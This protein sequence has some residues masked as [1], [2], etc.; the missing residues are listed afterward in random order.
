MRK[1]VIYDYSSVAKELLLRLGSEFGDTILVVKDEL[2][3]SVAARDGFHPV[4]MDLSNDENLLKIGVGTSVSDFFC[5]SDNDDTN[6]FVTLSVRAISHETNIIARASDADSK[7]KLILA[8]ANETIDF[9]EIGA[10]RAFHL[11]R[12]PTALGFLDSILY[13]DDNELQMH[14]IRISE[15]KV[16]S[17]SA[18]DK[19][20]LFEL[21]I[22]NRYNLIV[23]GVLDNQISRRFVFNVNSFN[24]TID[25]GD[26]L[27][28]IGKS[29]EIERFRGECI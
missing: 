12:R 8:G 17:G 14:G 25:A 29:E 5:V 11:L 15:I 28:V 19:K 23:L 2:G 4:L 9:N 22:K 13:R 27:V 20:T 1:I 16:A 24:H 7:K 3:Y 10:N 6:L 18:T 21:D 26:V